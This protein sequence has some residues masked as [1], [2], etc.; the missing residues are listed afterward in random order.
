MKTASVI[1]TIGHAAVLLYALVSFSGQTYEAT[2]QD[3]LPVDLVSEKDFSQLTKGTKEAPKAE[4][5]KP[6]V[7]KIDTP[8]PAEEIKPKVSEKQE[9]K[10][11]SAAPPMPETKPDPI[12]DKI[13]KQDEQKEVK[14]EPKPLPP[15]RPPERKQPKFDAD[16]IA[17]LLD[18]RDPQ[19]NAA[20]GAEVN[21][22]PSLGAASGESA[23]L[24]QSEIDALR[25][26][27]MAL[28]NFPAGIQNPEQYIIR[29]R[30]RLGRDGKLVG[31]PQVLTSGTGDL[32]NTA[33]DSAIRA[34]FRGQPFNMLKPE[35]YDNWKDIEVTFDPK[36]MFRG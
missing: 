8:K 27:L 14:A 16:K 32:F 12:A 21:S 26:R 1:S 2:P 33:R 4:K 15:R 13:K 29:V 30:I 34:I 20:T 17:A 18:K 5:P 6:V 7:E 24:S 25:S 11:V 36:D 22:A 9:I 31:P 10:T 23:N 35:H 28:W 19:R 3:S